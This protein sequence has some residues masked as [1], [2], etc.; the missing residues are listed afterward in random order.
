MIFLLDRTFLRNVLLLLKPEV[1]PVFLISLMCTKYKRNE[2]SINMCKS[3]TKEMNVKS[4]SASRK[5]I[6][7]WFT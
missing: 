1:R 7:P 5:Q 6:I 2:C 3:D 4:T